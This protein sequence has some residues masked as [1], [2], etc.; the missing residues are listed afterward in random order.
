MC[1]KIKCKSCMEKL[2]EKIMWN[3]FKKNWWENCTLYI[4]QCTFYSIQCTVYSVQCSMYCKEMLLSLWREPQCSSFWEW[5]F[6]P[7]SC[8]AS[9]LKRIPEQL[10]RTSKWSEIWLSGTQNGVKFGCWGPPNGVKFGFSGIFCNLK[11]Y[12]LTFSHKSQCQLDLWSKYWKLC[13][14]PFNCTLP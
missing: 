14:P 12:F 5:N 7:G 1:G 6:W 2:C 8:F 4:V 9:P 11:I 13:H 10:S 3:F